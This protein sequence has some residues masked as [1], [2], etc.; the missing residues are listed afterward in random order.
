MKI[1]LTLFLLLAAA[2]NSHPNTPQT[3]SLH[4]NKGR[5]YAPFRHATPDCILIDNIT[6]LPQTDIIPLSTPAGEAVITFR[7]ANL[8]AHP[9]KRFPFIDSEG[10]EQRVKAPVWSFMLLMSNNDTLRLTVRSI[11][12]STFDSGKAAAEVTLS[13]SIF[14]T[15]STYLVDLP[16][17]DPHSG[18][19]TWEINLSPSRLS[20]RAGSPDL[21]EILDIPRQHLNLTAFGFEAAPGA[22][23]QVSDIDLSLTEA[24]SSPSTWKGEEAF[25]AR[26]K[27]SKD[28]LEGYWAIFDRD[29]EESLLR[30]GGDYR[31]ALMKESNRYIAY[32]LSGAATNNKKWEQGMVKAIL[33][34]GPFPEVYNVEWIDSEG[35]PISESIVAQLE[36]E[37]LLSIQF[38]YHNSS[39]RLRKIPRP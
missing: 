20:I 38:P 3:T 8:H 18:A 13:S 9:G 25:K 27:N 1:V 34:P 26:V 21:G 35:Q 12:L 5:G 14:S 17:F 24:H 33:A 39:I 2:L 37:E 31:L 16:D 4:F 19:N 6:S 22:L 30:L 11:E 7:A 10:R 28:P 36:G 29:L 32:Y 23:L 15:P